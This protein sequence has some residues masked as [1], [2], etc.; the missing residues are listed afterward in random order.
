MLRLRLD[1]AVRDEIVLLSLLLNNYLRMAA[2]VDA[3][4]ICS[5]NR[6]EP[7][8][9]ADCEAAR[10]D[11]S[12]VKFALH[13]VRVLVEAALQALLLAMVLQ[14]D[15]RDLISQLCHDVLLEQLLAVELSVELFCVKLLTFGFVRY[16]LRLM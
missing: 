3:V 4:G 15:A 16:I 2:V 6:W 9:R 8:M 7:H 13:N 1:T 11:H 14:G 10:F 12:A 5:I